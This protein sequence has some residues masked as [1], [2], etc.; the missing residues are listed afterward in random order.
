MLRSPIVFA[1]LVGVAQ[2]D[3]A[4]GPHCQNCAFDVAALEEFSVDYNV[5]QYTEGTNG[6]TTHSLPDAL[7]SEH[8]TI[9]LHARNLQ[10][11]LDSH[12]TFPNGS[13]PL[14]PVPLSGMEIHEE[15][16]VNGATGQA[17]FHFASPIVNLCVQLDHLPPVAQMEHGMIDAQLQQAEQMAPQVMQ[18]HGRSISVD[19]EPCV[20]WT[21]R[22]PNGTP[23]AFL[24]TETTTHPKFISF[25]FGETRPARHLP[26]FARQL[27]D[28]LA[29][30]FDNYANS[31]GDQFAV[32][33]CEVES[34]TSTQNFLDENP[35]A[36]EFVA[37]RIAQHQIRLQ[38][39]LEPVNLNTRFNFIPLELADL[40]IPPAPECT[41][42]ELAQMPLQGQ[43]GMQAAAFSVCAFVMGVAATFAALR[44]RKTVALA[45]QMSA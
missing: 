8:G 2:S 36:R 38:A 11:K 34:Q 15:L 33:A 17:S 41:N 26:P 44:Q 23:L 31:V 27:L 1:T 37:N 42:S 7:P 3:G 21:E 29:V 18:G 45:D 43:T 28:S 4:F 13:P 20:G 5:V 12:A 16:H 9:A 22:H 19:G 32:R 40:M 35:D 14:G 10:L 25:C 6:F 30:K 39:L 24:F